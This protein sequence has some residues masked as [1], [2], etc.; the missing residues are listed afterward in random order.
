MFVSQNTNPKQG[1]RWKKWIMSS[2]RQRALMLHIP[3][4][5]P[6]Q[7]E[8]WKAHGLDRSADTWFNKEWRS[9]VQ[10]FTFEQGN[11]RQTYVHTPVA[12][13]F[14]RQKYPFAS[15]MVSAFWI[16]PPTLATVSLPQLKFDP[17]YKS[18]KSLNVTYEIHRRLNGKKTFDPPLCS[19]TCTGYNEAHFRFTQPY[20]VY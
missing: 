10:F 1:T 19:R 2:S 3:S 9:V 8:G 13:V 15:Q 14:G 11:L 20:V 6:R 16:L 7:Q 12:C 18:R 4:F 17:F 5:E